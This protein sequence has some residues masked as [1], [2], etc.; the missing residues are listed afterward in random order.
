M[1]TA[2]TNKK[3]RELITLLRDKKLI[4]RPDFQRRLVWST[5]DKNNFIDT[6]LKGYPF[7]EIFIADSSVNLATGDGLQVLVDG[8]QR[9]TTLFE[10]FNNSTSLKL[11]TIPAYNSLSSD[12]QRD[13]LNYDVAVRD[14]GAVTIEE[15]KEVFK[16]INETSYPLNPME[17][18]NAVYEGALKHFAE[19]IAEMDFFENHRVFNAH[20]MKRMG[21]VKYILSIIATMFVGYFN[22]DEE[23]ESILERFND[24]FQHADEI[25]QRINFV[26]SYLEDCLF[27]K[28]SRIWKKVDLFTAFIEIDAIGSENIPPPPVTKKNLKSFYDQV[29]LASIGEATGEANEYYLV[30]VQATNDKAS[31][32]TRGKIIR[33]VI[34]RG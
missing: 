14:L 8:Q 12:A 31:R 29:G 17:L 30:A 9:V 11:K 27:E 16:R 19:K 2:A 13:F 1:K 24:D 26:I 33:N 5:E 7:P 25:K 23:L 3:V 22:R 20:D 15:I 4:P 21:D 10:Y 28:E 18:N 34:L 32:L 6:L